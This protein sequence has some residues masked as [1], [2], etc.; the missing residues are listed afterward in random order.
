MRQEILTCDRC[1]N[2]GGSDFKLYHVALGIKEYKS[3]YYGSQTFALDD[4]LYR[5]KELCQE[6]VYALGLQ[7]PPKKEKKEVEQT[8]PTLEDM[9]REMIREELENK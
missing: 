2:S 7:I 3:N 8:A 1:K 4:H 9:I 6:C 5:S